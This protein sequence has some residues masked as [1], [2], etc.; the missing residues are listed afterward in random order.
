MDAS[1]KNVC[2]ISLTYTAYQLRSY[3]QNISLR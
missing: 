3:K 2:N 1:L